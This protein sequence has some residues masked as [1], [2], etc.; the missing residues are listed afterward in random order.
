[1][2]DEP[3][4]RIEGLEKTYSQGT[5]LLSR[6]FGS[7]DPIIAVDDVNLSLDRGEIV[8]VIGESGCGKTT[9]LEVVA[10]LEPETGGSVEFKGTPTSEFDKRDWKRFRKDV[11]IVF[12][13]PYEAMDPKMNVEETLR[14]PLEIH[15]IADKTDR[16]YSALE[17][18]ELQPD[19]YANRMPGQLSGGEK[20]RV[21][22]ARALV[23]EPDVLLTDEPVSMLDV[24]TQAS[25]LNLLRK[26][27]AETD[28]AIMYISHDISTVANICETVHTMY[29]GRIVETAKTMDLI[30]D[31]KHPYTQA[32]ISAVPKM[33]PDANRDRTILEGST[34]ENTGTEGCRFKERCPERM[35]ICE[36]TP[37]DL[38]VGPGRWVACFLYDDVETESSPAERQ[39]VSNGGSA[40]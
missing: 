11:Q 21:S 29:L 35:D 13:N 9:L 3:L 4:L 5:S 7:A 14:E 39:S 28:T 2:S 24:S 19:E 23:L 20:Q 15:D 30:T 37:P 36:R 6:L 33:D 27:N 18:V 31:P 1:M 40:R 38:D 32:L 10:G 22:I 17:R 34:S 25:I 16:V 8:G 26:L 12:Q